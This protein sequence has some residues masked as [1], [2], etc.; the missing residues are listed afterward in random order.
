MDFAGLPLATGL[1]VVFGL[2]FYTATLA[3]PTEED[4]ARAP[5]IQ[6]LT[7]DENQPRLT[8]RPL[9]RANGRR[10]QPST[11]ADAAGY[12]FARRRVLQARGRKARR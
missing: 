1:S 4:N 5:K 9:G 12:G 3:M 2:A 7:L 11:H 10:S 8:I 6:C